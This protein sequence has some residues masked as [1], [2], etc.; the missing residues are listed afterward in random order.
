MLSGVSSGLFGWNSNN[1][2]DKQPGSPGFFYVANMS[3]VYGIWDPV[4]GEFPIKALERMSNDLMHRSLEGFGTWV[5]GPIGFGHGLAVVSPQSK[6]EQSP[7]VWQ[8]LVISAES[9]LDERLALMTAMKLDPSRQAG[10][11]DPELI[12]HAYR[13]WGLSFAE[14]LTG[15]F[16]VALWDRRQ[17]RLILARDQV[18]AKMLLY[19]HQNGRVSFASELRALVRSGVVETEMDKELLLDQVLGIYDQP[20]RTI[21]KDIHKVPPATLLVFDRADVRQIRYWD[22]SRVAPIRYR[23]AGDYARHL[24]GLMEQAVADRLPCAFPLG[25]P[26]SGGLDSSSIAVLAAPMLRERSEVLY[27]ASSILGPDYQGEATDELAYIQAVLEQEKDL[28]PAF[29]HQTDLHPFA[30]LP[31]LQEK[32]LSQVSQWHYV[33]EAIYRSL[34]ERGVR[35]ILPGNLGDMTVSNK[36]I[37]PLAMA[38]RSGHWLDLLKLLPEYCREYRVTGWIHMVKADLLRPG[39]PSWM[40]D[41]IDQLRG[42]QLSWEID[43]DLF[44][45]NHVERKRVMDRARAWFQQLQQSPVSVPDAIWPLGMDANEEAW[46]CQAAHHG[47]EI[48]MPWVDRRII[49]YLTTLPPE[50]FRPAGVRR[51]LIRQAMADC[52]PPLVSHRRTKGHFSPGFHDCMKSNLSKYLIDKHLDSSPLLI[53]C[54]INV[55]EL[56]NRFELLS[57]SRNYN[58]FGPQYL[59]YVKMMQLVTLPQ[60]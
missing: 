13:T 58:T 39:L 31:V 45:W 6:L 12:L 25:L 48:A 10:I 51:G 44:T 8:D 36:T 22:L 41:W 20:T 34:A 24:R 26:L 57:R 7:L 14:H 2:F 33:D 27:T 18:G 37:F 60:S 21:W 52:L 9:R 38:L 3:A 5:D 47:I 15:D 1:T 30:G 28:V 29:V 56:Y 11:T 55:M 59:N 49:E 35:R 46:E 42:H 50:A 17:G 16:A 19:S 23:D 4:G 32:T 54:R 53:D 40:K 43:A